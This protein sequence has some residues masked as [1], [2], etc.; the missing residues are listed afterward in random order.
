MKRLCNAY[1]C[2]LFETTSEKTKLTYIQTPRTLASGTYPVLAPLLYPVSGV[3]RLP[4]AKDPGVWSPDL[5]PD[6]KDPGV[7]SPD[8]QPDAKDPGVW[9]PVHIDD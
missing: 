4:D 2:L 1:V 6:A 9:L 7:W 8:L 3:S 5:Q